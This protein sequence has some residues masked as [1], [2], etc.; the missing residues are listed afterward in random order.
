[1][2]RSFRSANNCDEVL[3]Q[4]KQATA[5]LLLLYDVPIRV[6]S[7]FRTSGLTV[8]PAHTDEKPVEKPPEKPDQKNRFTVKTQRNFAYGIE[9]LPKT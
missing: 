2:K 4:T 7:Y 8:H 5:L 1:M 9:N 6:L 3:T